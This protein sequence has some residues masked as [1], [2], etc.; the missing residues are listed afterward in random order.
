MTREN[1]I[2]QSMKME[3]YRLHTV[4]QWP[5]SAHKEAVL[6]SI[7]SALER[8]H[9]DSPAPFEPPRCMACACRRA[10][11]A[12]LQFPARS[13]NAPGITRLAA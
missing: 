6:A 13:Q 3:H 2:E 8:L 10:E 7:H 9:A 4:E 1:R 5:R 12:V 11:S